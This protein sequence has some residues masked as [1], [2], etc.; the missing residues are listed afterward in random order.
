[1]IQQ[2][3]LIRRWGIAK[4]GKT[5]TGWFFGFTLHLVIH[6][7][8]EIVSFRLTSVN[9]DDRDPM[10]ESKKHEKPA[11]GTNGYFERGLY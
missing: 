2:G 7:P 4:S 1:M 11:H 3:E 10:P 9:T 6:H 8:A 5:S